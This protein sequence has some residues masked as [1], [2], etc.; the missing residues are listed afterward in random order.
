MDV[1]KEGGN[2]GGGG[3]GKGAGAHHGEEGVSRGLSDRNARVRHTLSQRGGD[4]HGKVGGGG[5]RWGVKRRVGEGGNDVFCISCTHR[6]P[7]DQSLSLFFPFL[8]FAPASF[9]LTQ[10]QI[11]TQN[12]RRQPP[13]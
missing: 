8:P 11:L 1:S 7:S 10:L 13:H 12:F 5:G 4:G 9:P 2:V 3:G 6:E